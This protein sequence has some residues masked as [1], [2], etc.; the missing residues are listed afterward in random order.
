[1]LRGCLLFVLLTG[2][3]GWT[4]SDASG[5][6]AGPGGLVRLGAETRVITD[7]EL[8]N[9]VYRGE[10]EWHYLGT[11]SAS[12]GLISPR[13]PH[14]SAQVELEF[15]PMD[16]YGAASAA[17]TEE[18]GSEASGTEENSAE[19]FGTSSDFSLKKAWVK[20]RFPG[21]KLTV[22]KTRLAW[23]Q[24]M[25]FN[26]GDLLFGSLNPVLDLTARELR[27]DTA[28]LTAVNIPLGPFAFA[29]AAV[30]P[31][32]LGLPGSDD[33]EDGVK[34]ISRSSLGGRLYFLAG[35]IKVEGGYLYKGEKKVPG[36]LPGH[37]PYLALQGNMGPDWYL[38]ASAAPATDEQIDEQDAEDDWEKTLMVSGG[39]FHLQELD[40]NNSLSLRLEALVLPNLYWEER[41]SRDT[42]YALYLYPELSWTGGALTVSLQS[43]VSPLDA[44]AMITTGASWNIY[45]GL[46]LLGYLTFLSGEDDDTFAW[47]RGDEANGRGSSDQ[48]NGVSLMCGLRYKF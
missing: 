18:G 40:R 23:G 12:L 9:T 1:M 24:G 10:E 2:A 41:E 33:T 15:Y 34:E 47:D 8:Y 3:V 22:G 48:V 35:D 32:S 7:M 38:A 17:G 43:V 29:E 4:G 11:G 45:Q 44:S 37:R 19:L 42:V 14:V 30:L 20:T 25:V 28:W 31:P 36:D 16:L 46:T 27:S 21:F 6:S 39:L 5:R 13:D 26:A